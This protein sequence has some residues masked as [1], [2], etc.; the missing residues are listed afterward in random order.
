MGDDPRGQGYM[1]PQI[2]EKLPF[3]FDFSY[4]NY[5][6][7]GSYHSNIEKKSQPM[8]LSPLKVFDPVNLQSPT[9]NSG[10]NFD[11]R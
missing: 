9:V 2:F 8:W 6:K 5:L 10:K 3:D 11:S 1:S 7:M 4:S